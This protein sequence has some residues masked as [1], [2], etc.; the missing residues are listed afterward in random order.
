MSIGDIGMTQNRQPIATHRI[1]FAA[2]QAAVIENLIDEGTGR[3]VFAIPGGYV[4]KIARNKK[5][6]IENGNENFVFQTIPDKYRESLCPVIGYQ[7]KHLIMPRAL[8]LIVTTINLDEVLA[9]NKPFLNY[10]QERYDL[11]ELDLF[12]P[13]NW[14]IYHGKP[15]LFDYGT[16]YIKSLINR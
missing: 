15:V 7:A 12:Y 14:G 6:L 1:D 10:L 8:P 13:D 11:N 3:S 5:G 9:L 4:L 16:T 2:L